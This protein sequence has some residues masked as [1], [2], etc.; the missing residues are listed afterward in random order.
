MVLVTLFKALR[1]M[2]VLLFKV[3]LAS[4]ARLLSTKASL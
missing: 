3:I 1:R 4:K 2:K